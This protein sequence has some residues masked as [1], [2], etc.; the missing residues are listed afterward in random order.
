M[1]RNGD[2][3]G[4]SLSQHLRKIWNFCYLLKAFQVLIR[5]RIPDP[6]NGDNS[7]L[8]ATNR[9]TS[10]PLKTKSNFRPDRNLFNSSLVRISEQADLC[11]ASLEK[12]CNNLLVVSLLHPSAPW[13]VVQ[14]PE[15]FCSFDPNKIARKAMPGKAKNAKVLEVIKALCKAHSYILSPFTS[16]KTLSLGIFELIVCVMI[17]GYID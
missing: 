17:C 11:N 10:R 2:I 8:S 4:F 5:A 14:N 16:G 12:C 9:S 1:F 3:S 6:E 7:Q 15:S 13:A